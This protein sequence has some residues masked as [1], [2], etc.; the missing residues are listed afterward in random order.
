MAPPIAFII[1]FCWLSCCSTN[2]STFSS[3][4][5]VISCYIF[6][7]QIE[8]E[9]VFRKIQSLFSFEHKQ[10]LLFRVKVSIYMSIFKHLRLYSLLHIITTLAFKLPFIDHL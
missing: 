5:I 10:K 8:K 4:Y 7:I 3:F 2:V 1:P 9:R 6:I